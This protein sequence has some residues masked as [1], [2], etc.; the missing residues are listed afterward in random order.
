[1]NQRYPD[2][3]ERKAM[4]YQQDVRGI[5]ERY[6]YGKD[7]LVAKNLSQWPALHGHSVE[8]MWGDAV[9]YLLKK[10]L[11]GLRQRLIGLEKKKAMGKETYYEYGLWRLSCHDCGYEGAP[12][13]LPNECPKCLSSNIKKTQGRIPIDDAIARWKYLIKRAEGTVIE[14]PGSAAEPKEVE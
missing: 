1:M 7:E 12:Y 14:P 5:A 13:P 8:E 2:L 11:P 6:L 9:A 10:V 3:E 4:G